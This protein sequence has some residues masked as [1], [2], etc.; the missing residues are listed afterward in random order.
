MQKAG[1]GLY[2]KKDR[3]RSRLALAGESAK[4]AS[5]TC[6]TTNIMLNKL[7]TWKFLPDEIFQMID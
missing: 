6:S 7:A 3:E 1:P 2:G 5:F 4:L